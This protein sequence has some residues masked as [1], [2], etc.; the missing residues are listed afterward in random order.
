MAASYRSSQ[1]S[2][3]MISLGIRPMVLVVIVA[4][5][6]TYTSTLLAHTP[7]QESEYRTGL[8]HVFGKKNEATQ[9][10]AKLSSNGSSLSN[11]LSAVMVESLEKA[12]EATTAFLS[13]NH[14]KEEE[15][16]G[17]LEKFAAMLACATYWGS[18]QRGTADYALDSCKTYQR[19]S[20]YLMYTQETHDTRV[21]PLYNLY[22]IFAIILFMILL[23]LA[24]KHCLQS[25]QSTGL[26]GDN[27][28]TN[29]NADHTLLTQ[30]PVP[31]TRKALFIEA[32]SQFLQAV[33]DASFTQ[34]DKLVGCCFLSHMAV[35]SD[36][37]GNVHSE[38]AR[39]VIGQ[40]NYA[41]NHDCKTKEKLSVREWATLPRKKAQ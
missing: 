39:R 17:S 31:E 14:H 28:T 18:Y 12:K 34:D 23:C 25:N 15:V 21:E 37:H 10:S 1:K 32:K 30:L 2:F 29:A 40:F 4:I 8:G 13:T 20:P 3:Q 24:C 5:L 7:D 36:E 38:Q 22:A 6:W 26:K 41:C 27:F 9:P 33:S 11:L 35:L 19:Y 16:D